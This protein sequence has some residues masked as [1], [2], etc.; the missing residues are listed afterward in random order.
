MRFKDGERKGEIRSGRE[1]RKR[2]G[3]EGR[4][5]GRGRSKFPNWKEM[6]YLRAESRG[7][8][9]LREKKCLEELML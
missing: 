3:G 7:E 2:G 4:G 6:A 9:S 8:K 1:R 5:E